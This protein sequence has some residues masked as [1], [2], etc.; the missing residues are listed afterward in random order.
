M[1]CEPTSLL[2]V[3]STIQRLDIVVP[4]ETERSEPVSNPLSFGSKP[5]G[6]ATPGMRSVSWKKF[7]PFSGSSR[8]CVPEMM[9]ET[10]P[11]SVWTATAAA[12][13]VNSSVTPPVV[14]WALTARVSE[15]FK[16]IFLNVVGL[17]PCA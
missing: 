5:S 7:R 1:R 16:A 9:P 14:S 3:P 2:L 4:P 10:S 13:T 17:N 11:P 6:A 15:T 12:S 8:A